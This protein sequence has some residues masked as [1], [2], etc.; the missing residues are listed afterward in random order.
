M[1]RRDDRDARDGNLVT[2]ART[3]KPENRAGICVRV[4]IHAIESLVVA[5][6]ALVA[7]S[8]AERAS[9]GGI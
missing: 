2:P 3:R 9:H 5:N 4:P 6:A 7:P 8:H 1:R